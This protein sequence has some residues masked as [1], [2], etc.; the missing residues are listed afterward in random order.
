MSGKTNRMDII[1]L[2]GTQFA[3]STIKTFIEEEAGKVQFNEGGHSDLPGIPKVSRFFLGNQEKIPPP[4]SWIFWEPRRLRK[5]VERRGD[6]CFSLLYFP[7]SFA[8]PLNQVG[9][10]N[11]IIDYNNM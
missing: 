1:I 9:L 3:Y 4:K 6:Y 10:N 7:V 11:D 2:L 5:T 8:D